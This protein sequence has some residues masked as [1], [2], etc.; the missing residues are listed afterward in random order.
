MKDSKAVESTVEP[1]LPKDECVSPSPSAV[2]TS[3]LFGL[4]TLIFLVALDF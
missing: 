3:Q 1:H 4:F 2:S